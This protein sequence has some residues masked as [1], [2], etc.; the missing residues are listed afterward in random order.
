MQQEK[1]E[2]DNTRVEAEK[3][4]TLHSVILAL[5]VLILMAYAATQIWV[6]R[7]GT[8]GHD[9]RYYID[10]SRSILHGKS[11]Y[12]EG[13][14]YIYPPPLAVFLIPLAPLSYDTGYWIWTL[15]GI[16][17]YG[18]AAYRSGW[19]GVRSPQRSGF[20]PTTRST[21]DK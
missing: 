7:S 8:P 19:L 2:P 6:V 21:T 3:R 4:L 17:V 10:A 9:Y 11:P 16:L 1:T 13:W 5:L 18:Y 15:I 12:A 20:R 14:W